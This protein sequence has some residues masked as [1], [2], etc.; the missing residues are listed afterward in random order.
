[1]S[2]LEIRDNNAGTP[3]VLA[4]ARPNPNQSGVVGFQGGTLYADYQQVAR[5]S[6]RI[7]GGGYLASVNTGFSASFSF[8]WV[9]LR[10]PPPNGVMPT[11]IFGEF[12]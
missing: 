11:V 5:V 4:T 2:G 7:C 12:Y 3:S 8:G 6:Q 10:T 9:R 1:M